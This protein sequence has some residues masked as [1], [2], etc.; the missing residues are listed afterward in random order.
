MVKRIWRQRRAGRPCSSEGSKGNHPG[1]AGKVPEVKTPPNSP[2][3]ND[4][5]R[6]WWLGPINVGYTFI[7]GE[8]TLVLI[9]DGSQI[10]SIMPAYAHEHSMVVGLLEELAGDPSGNAIQ[11]IGGVQIGALGYVVFRVQIE[12]IPSYDEEQVALVIQDNTKFGHRVPIILGTPTIHRVVR[13]MKE[14][15]ME[16]ASPEWQRVKMGYEI[17]NRLF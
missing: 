15:E 9:D 10:N 4:D 3:W 5:P 1:P 14:S 7:D 2:Y 17:N 11:G 13:S 6:S 8:R 16:N 12:G